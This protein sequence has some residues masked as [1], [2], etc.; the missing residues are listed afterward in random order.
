MIQT[1]LTFY[2]WGRL[3]SLHKKGNGVQRLGHSLS[4]TTGWR[5]D[6]QVTMWIWGVMVEGGGNSSLYNV[7]KD[8]IL[9]SMF[10]KCVQ[11]H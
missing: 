9:K 10:V 3:F 7:M 1:R 5:K 6:A 4:S 2:S 11:K 8:K